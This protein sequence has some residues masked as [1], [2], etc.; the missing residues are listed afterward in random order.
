MNKLFIGLLIIAAGAGVYFFVLKKKN[1]TTGTKIN[2]ELIIGKWEQTSPVDSGEVNYRYEFQ[3][4]GLVLKSASD[5]AKADTTHFEWT[6][7]GQLVWKDGKTDNT[8]KTFVVLQ[9]TQD[10]LTMQSKDSTIALFIKMK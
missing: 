10:S 9:L 4:E 6:K 1:S 8:G 7:A 3:K 5:S 2:K